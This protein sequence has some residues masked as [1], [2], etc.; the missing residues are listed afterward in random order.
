[1]FGAGGTPFGGFGA[2]NSNNAFGGL[3]FDSLL[4]PNGGMPNT[5]TT[6]PMF[7]ASMPQTVVPP[8]D[9]VVRYAAQ[10][11]QLQDMG[12]ADQAA[13]VRAL[14]SSGGNVNAAVERLLGGN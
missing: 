5:N 3:N 11:Q 2:N 9:P 10:L 13:N 14:Q 7:G 6:N 1:M 12:F 8:V 4:A